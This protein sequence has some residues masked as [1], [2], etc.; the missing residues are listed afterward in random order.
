VFRICFAG[1]AFVSAEEETA[2]TAETA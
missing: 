2:E 1:G